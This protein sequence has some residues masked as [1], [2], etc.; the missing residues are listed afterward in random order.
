MIDPSPAQKILPVVEK[1]PMG[2]VATYG[3]IARFIG[4][5]LAPADFYGAAPVV[6]R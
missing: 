5:V 6:R 1:I 3:Q 2:K 4:R